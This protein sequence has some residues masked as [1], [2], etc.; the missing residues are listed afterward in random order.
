[1]LAAA[2]HFVRK[3]RYGQ[4]VCPYFEGALVASKRLAASNTKEGSGPA[5][6]RQCLWP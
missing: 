3:S 6:L 2:S 1:M 4:T 5:R